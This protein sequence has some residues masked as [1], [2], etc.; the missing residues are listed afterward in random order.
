MARNLHPSSALPSIPAREV[1]CLLGKLAQD[2]RLADFYER[3]RNYTGRDHAH[4]STDLAAHPQAQVAGAGGH[5]LEIDV[6]CRHWAV[7]FVDGPGNSYFCCG[8]LHPHGELRGYRI[9]SGCVGS[10]R[11]RSGL[12]GAGSQLR[13]GRRCGTG[14]D[15][16]KG[17]MAWM[18]TSTALVLFMSVPALALFYGG[19]V[20]EKNMLSVLMQ[21]FVGFSL[22]TVLWCVYGYSLAFTEGPNPFIGGLSR[23]FL[24][25][26]FNPADGS[27]SNAATFDKGVPLNELVYVGF[28]ATFAAITCCLILGSLVERIKFSAALIFMVFW[29]T[30]AYL[31]VAHMVWFWEGPDAYTSAPGVADQMN[32]HAGTSGRWVRW[33]SPAAPSCTSTPV[34]RASLARS[35]SAAHRPGQGVH[36][37]A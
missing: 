26:T 1:R 31:P 10:R 8:Q 7:G 11:L 13:S 30:F 34:W 9:R 20:R 33:T 19:L 24:N 36:G 6:P 25:G 27:F 35:S 21:V 15:P 12:L 18:M 4:R 14:S 2:A 3:K 37:S 22:I 17:D 32:A 29:F 5:P 28:Q 16:D 23:L